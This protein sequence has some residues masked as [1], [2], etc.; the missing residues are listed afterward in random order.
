MPNGPQG[1]GAAGCDLGLWKEHCAE[2]TGPDL[3]RPCR[4]RSSYQVR[5][6][7]GAPASGSACVGCTVR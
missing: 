1:S 5:L 4:H 2:F 3:A 7:R 6:G